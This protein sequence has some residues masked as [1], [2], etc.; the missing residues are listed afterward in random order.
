MAE[1]VTQV[2]PARQLVAVEYPG[3]VRSAEAAMET[4]GGGAAVA[5]A[6]ADEGAPLALRFRPR[7]PLTRPVLADRSPCAALLLRVSRP[8]GSSAGDGDAPATATVVAHVRAA[9]RFAPAMA[10]YQYLPLEAGATGGA[11]AGRKGGAVAGGAGRADPSE[12]LG[13][14]QPLQLLP[15]LFAASDVSYDYAFRGHRGTGISAAAGDGAV[16][17]VPF[18]APLVPPEAAPPAAAGAT[19]GGGEAELARAV[20]EELAGRPVWLPAHMEQALA[21][22]GLPALPPSDLDAALAGAAYRFASGPFRGAWVRRGYDPRADSAARR[23]QV[24]RLRLPPGVPRP[25]HSARMASR[26]PT[27]AP[28]GGG[29]EPMEVNGGAGASTSA[30]AAAAAPHWPGGGYA[31]ACA[32]AAPP[33]SSRGVQVLLCDL[34]DA[35]VQ[36][37]VQARARAP[38]RSSRRGK[39]TSGLAAAAAALL[40]HCCRSHAWAAVTHRRIP[41]HPT[42]I[43]QQELPVTERCGEGTGWFSAGGWQQLKA[44]LAARTARSLAALGLLP[45]GGSAFAA[46]PAAPE[47]PSAGPSAPPPAAAA[48]AAAPARR[49]RPPRKQPAAPPSPLVPPPPAVAAAAGGE[50]GQ[51]SLLHSIMRSLELQPRGGAGTVAAAGAAAAAAGPSSA[52]SP[53]PLLPPG[54]RLPDWLLMGDGDDEFQLLEGL[55]DAGS[56]GNYSESLGSSEDR[57]EDDGGGG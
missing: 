51:V 35:N 19:A 38:R 27:P 39:T 56:A 8:K 45:D 5:A 1:R 55:S 46:P 54:A 26:Q 34:Q 17:L 40:A 43:R 30:A 31:E 2:V 21:A 57:S 25:R 14:P 7:D 11:P 42:H 44:A 15:P 37:L 53:L 52:A 9:Y 49:G 13:R 28:G 36:R 18:A 41:S 4:L 50:P 12:P 3:L 10:D 33:T 29:A 22:R 20:R 47:A 48:A 16:P 23:F 32:F 24:A 6:L